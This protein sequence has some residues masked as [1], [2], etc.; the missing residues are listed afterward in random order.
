VT[1]LHGLNI[2]RK[3][4]SRRWGDQGIVR[5]CLVVLAVFVMAMVPIIGP[6]TTRAQSSCRIGSTLPLIPDVINGSQSTVSRAG[7]VFTFNFVFGDPS[8]AGVITICAGGSLTPLCNYDGFSFRPALSSSN[9][10]DIV[11]GNQCNTTW[12]I[13]ASD[14]N[15]VTVGWRVKFEQEHM[16]GSSERQPPKHSQSVFPAVLPKGSSTVS[17][18]IQRLLATQTPVETAN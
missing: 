13:T 17:R 8:I 18:A 5:R 15:S 4:G 12:Q 16:M 10:Q 3:N 14:F 9:L 7:R 11:G 6:R 2:F 1:R